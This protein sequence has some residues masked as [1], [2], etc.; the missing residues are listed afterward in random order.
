M[1]PL[2][3]LTLAACM[4]EASEPPKP[5]EML[6]H[7]IVQ[8]IDKTPV[9]VVL[10]EVKTWKK[11]VLADGAAA[12]QDTTTTTLIPAIEKGNSTVHWFVGYRLH[13][14]EKPGDTTVTYAM[15]LETPTTGGGPVK[16][17]WYEDHYEVPRSY[18]MGT[19]RL[20][21]GVDGAANKLDLQLS[22][23]EYG[24]PLKVQGMVR[25]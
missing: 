13:T 2:T 19:G 9:E 24:D 6:A 15:L 4:T 8:P 20:T 17:L 18:Y 16:A 23:A 1:I 14:R 22:E 21:L 10:S 11:G 5:P 7:V 25:P 12:H 3:V